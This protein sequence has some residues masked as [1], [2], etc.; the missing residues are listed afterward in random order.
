MHVS[1]KTKLLGC[2]LDLQLT[3]ESKKCFKP[4]SSGIPLLLVWNM[5]LNAAISF[6]IISVFLLPSISINYQYIFYI[7]SGMWVLLPVAGWIGDSFLGRYRAIVL[8]V[9]VTMMS[10]LILL[11]ITVMLQFNWTPIPAIT[12][13]CIYLLVT[14]CS[15]GT[16]AISMLPFIIDQMIGASADD[17]SAIVQWF[18][19]SK[20]LGISLTYLL[21]FLPIEQLKQYRLVICL[22]II[23][24]CLSSVLITDCVCH[25]WLDI[26]YKSS[27]PFKTIFKVLDY[28]RK[29]KYPEHRSAFT[30]IDEEEPSRLDYGKHKFG[31]P[32]TEEEVE[33]VKTIFRLLPLFVSI[34]GAFITIKMISTKNLFQQTS[35]SSFESADL[36]YIIAMMLP[37]LL[38]PA[39][40]LIVF[41]LLHNRIPSLIKRVG[42]GLLIML[43]GNLLNL[44]VD[45]IGHLHSNNTQCMFSE[46]NS[47]SANSLPIPL[48]WLLISATVTGV[49]ELIMTCSLIEFGMAQSPN[50]MRGVMMGLGATLFYFGT[51]LH[52]ALEHILGN[53]SN[54]TPSC[55]FYYYLVL[56]ILLILSLVLFTIATKRYKLR[57]RDRHVNIQAIAEEHYERYFDQE[58]EYMREAAGKNYN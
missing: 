34:F 16:F 41:P 52:Y 45:T 19:F 31:G 9:F 25:K 23:F 2:R 48:Y 38:I 55:G 6:T 57:E 53:F 21:I 50:R 58:E 7:W 44:T 22:M 15:M 42:A 24:L 32:F 5:L 49:G 47:E 46:T 12:L 1:A 40:R 4:V 35:S 28:A 33:D 54:A 39:Y 43:I 26:H 20:S 36:Q 8:G 10:Y 56:S 30:Y 11:C 51:L 17:I 37:I 14:T 29:T 3:M 27:S 18:Y 13:L